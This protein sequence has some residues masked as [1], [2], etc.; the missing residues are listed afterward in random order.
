MWKV[1]FISFPSKSP[2]KARVVFKLYFGVRCQL[3]KTDYS[4]SPFTWD[5]IILWIEF[6]RLRFKWFFSLCSVWSR[7]T[8]NN[9][10]LFS[11][12]CKVRKVNFISFPS[13][14]PGKARVVFKLY[15]GVRCQL[16]K[17]TDYSGLSE[18]CSRKYWL[19]YRS[20]NLIRN[21]SEFRKFWAQIYTSSQ[22]PLTPKCLV[23]PRISC[24]V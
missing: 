9:S 4:Y 18:N 7:F 5:Q 12:F 2:G 1:N 24:K 15:L 11:R 20:P 13:K 14:S 22:N 3:K 17:K 16:K 23:C 21:F 8:C 6:W 19:T 10:N